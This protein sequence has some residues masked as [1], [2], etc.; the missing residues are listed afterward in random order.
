MTR[1]D[2]LAAIQKGFAAGE[3]AEHAKNAGSTGSTTCNSL[4][5]NDLPEPADGTHEFSLGVPGVPRVPSAS[6]EPLEP[7]VFC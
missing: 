1:I 7:L 5:I 3:N 2:W 6:V 4:K